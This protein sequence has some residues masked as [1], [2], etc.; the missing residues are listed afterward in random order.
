MNRTSVCAVLLGAA[1][2]AGGCQKKAARPA[3]TASPAMSL[4]DDEKAIYALGAALGQQAAQQV[5]PLGL[6][7]AEVEVLKKGIAASLA[8]EP[9]R[10]TMEQYRERLQKL[11]GARSAVTAAPEK[12]KGNAFREAA[13]AEPGALRLPSGL[14]YSTIRP[15]KGASP[16][17]TD[18]VR[19]HYHG[20]LR[21]GKVFDSS[22]Q[23]GQP[24]D[25]P[26]NQVI[27][28]WTEGVQHMKVGEKARLVCPPEL[29]YGDRG[30]PD[31]AIPP[32]ATIAFEVELLGI[33]GRR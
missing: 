24:V 20:T 15:G 12:E 21:D 28:C 32:G 31:G 10:Y 33:Q 16:G 4:T 1:A 9:P 19:V 30:T 29:A 18:V 25:F 23:R 8:G 3:E 22:V 5:R 6:T 27:P 11:A 26:L 2:L 17:P 13:A 14:V 7:P